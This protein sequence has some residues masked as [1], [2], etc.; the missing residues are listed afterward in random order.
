MLRKCLEENARRESQQENP[1]KYFEV[2]RIMLVTKIK[3]KYPYTYTIQRIHI[4]TFTRFSVEM[5]IY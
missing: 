4:I 1:L 3:T 2:Q 5:F